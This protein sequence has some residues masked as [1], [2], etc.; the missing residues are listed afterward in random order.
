MSTAPLS[1]N[2]FLRERGVHSDVRSLLY[3][4]ARGVKYINFAIRAGNTGKVGSEN[5]SG[6]QQVALDVMADQLILDELHKSELCECVA[7]E[8]QAACVDT[9]GPRGKFF[10]AFDPLDGSSLIDTNLA[11][12]SIFGIWSNTDIINKR[13]EKGMLA[14]CFAVYGPRITFTI[15]IKDKGTHEFELND[16]GEFILTKADIKI[17]PETKY[18]APGNLK[19]YAENG[20]YKAV[21]DYWL[22]QQR[23]LRYS[24]GM[25]P[26]LNHILCKGQGI[27][28][29]PADSQHSNGKLR[30][31]FECAPMA[32]VFEE[33]G[34]AALNQAGERVLDTVVTEYHQRTPIFIGS[35]GEV[36][37]VVK[38]MSS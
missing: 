11:V 7:S 13:A 1:F 19:A 15:A 34:G 29:Y 9:S 8:E 14:A 23:K 21:T 31:L 5:S 16:V 33:A 17:D 37:N 18:F 24:G 32:F 26:D 22:S 27:F 36:E 2:H 38:M 28:S 12:G 30:L 3:H 20:K 10:V 4:L 25:V 6:E 35:K